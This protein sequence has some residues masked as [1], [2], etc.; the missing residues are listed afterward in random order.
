MGVAMRRTVALVAILALLAGAGWLGPVSRADDP[1][2]RDPKAGDGKA[3]ITLPK[4]PKVVVLRYDPGAGGFIRKGPPPYLQ[5]RADGQVTVTSLFDGSKKESK[6]PDKQLQELL[7]FVIQENDFFN[8]TQA[9]I[10]K[11]VQ[12]AMAKGPAIAVGGAGTSVI[13]VEANGKRH[14]VSYRAAGAYLR[15][16][17]KVRPLAQFAAVEKRLSDLAAAVAKGK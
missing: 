3:A 2:A 1:P 11:G 5:I 16:Y 12:E 9:K 17:P 15:A 14:E 8:L 13:G 6:L 7:R 10:A 4:D